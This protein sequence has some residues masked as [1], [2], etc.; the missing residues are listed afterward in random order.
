MKRLLQFIVLVYMLSNKDKVKEVLEIISDPDNYRPTY[1]EK[2][3]LLEQKEHGWELYTTAELIKD[4]VKDTLSS[5]GKKVVEYIMLYLLITIYFDEDFNPIIPAEQKVAAH[6]LKNLDTLADFC[7]ACKEH[8]PSVREQ[9]K[10]FRYRMQVFDSLE[11][12][13]N[14]ILKRFP[15]VGW[16]IAF[17]VQEDAVMLYRKAYPIKKFNIF[18]VYGKLRNLLRKLPPD[19]VKRH[20]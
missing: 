5:Y 3:W 15:E 18:N 14:K 19:L 2:E 7:E 1:P 10:F 9:E 17:N 4:R 16:D 13:R 12:L 8:L 20:F 6:L 11:S